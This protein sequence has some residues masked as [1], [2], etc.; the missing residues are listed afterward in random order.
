MSYTVFNKESILTIDLKV[1]LELKKAAKQSPDRR[2]RLCLHEYPEQSVNEMLLVMCKDS[3]IK[4]HRHPPGKHESY[5]I[6][7][8]EM[9]VL[10]FDDMGNV[11]KKIEMGMPGSDKIFMYRL[12]KNIWHQPVAKTEFVAYCEIFKG[13]FNK[14][15]DV[16]YAKWPG[17]N[18]K[19]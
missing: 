8:G 19:T 14:E 16:E 12:S 1:L 13:P 3:Y 2:A 9:D 7:E 4:P 17:T 6:I 5:Y 10:L 18:N 11:I 15:R